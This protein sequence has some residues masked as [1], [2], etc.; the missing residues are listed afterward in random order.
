MSL[1]FESRRT[2]KTTMPL[3]AHSIPFYRKYKINHMCE[4]PI[5]GRYESESNPCMQLIESKL[6]IENLKKFRWESKPELC[7][8][9]TEHSTH[10]S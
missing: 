8:D 3:T 10:L 6:L 1:Y 7:D 9:R 5:R 4:L 2:K